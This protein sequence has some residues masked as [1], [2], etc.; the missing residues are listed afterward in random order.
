VARA[1]RAD[2]A[3]NGAILIALTGYG[4]AEDRDQAYQAGF[5]HHLTK[6][7]SVDQLRDLLLQFSRTVKSDSL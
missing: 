6:P 5:D 7:V 1:M 4:Q 3:L 2:P